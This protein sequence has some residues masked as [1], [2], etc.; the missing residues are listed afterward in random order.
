MRLADAASKIGKRVVFLDFQLFD[1]ST[2]QDEETFFRH[3]CTWLTYELDIDDEVTSYWRAPM[4]NVQRCTRYMEKH[5]LKNVKGSLVLAMDEVD[6]IFDA[7]FRSDFFAMLRSWHNARHKPIWRTLDLA[8]VTSTEPYQLVANLNQSPFNVGEVIELEDFTPEQVSDLNHRH[9]DPFHP[10]EEHRLMTL[11][12]GQPYLVRRALYL[13]ASRH[14]TPDE[15]FANAVADRGPFG[16]HLRYHLFRIYDNPVLVE[17]MQQVLRRSICSDERVFF[18]LRGSGLVKRIG[19]T[20]VPRCQLYTDY[21]I[22][23]LKD[24]C[25]V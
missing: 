14:L 20:V 7:T 10:S 15:L 22:Q 21:F 13:A 5:L 4:G 25:D 1:A 23:H 8:L 18:R 16:D 24:N 3:F 2:L 12:G 11:L 17:G 6:K 9:G 19:S